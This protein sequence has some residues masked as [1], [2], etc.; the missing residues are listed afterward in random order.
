VSTRPDY[1]TAALAP[2]TST[3][4]LPYRRTG[5]RPTLERALTEIAATARI[6]AREGK[7]DD[8]LGLLESFAATAADDDGTILYTVH[9]DRKDP[10]TFVVWELYRDREALR[11]HAENP[12]LK[13][14]SATLRELAETIDVTIHAHVAGTRAARV[15]G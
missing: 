13:A 1:R 5:W 8:L 14:G 15:P 10:A 6:V 4:A 7:A 11:L 3:V 2:A 9:R 12:R